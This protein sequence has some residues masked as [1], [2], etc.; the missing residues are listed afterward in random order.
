MCEGEIKARGTGVR[1][2]ERERCATDLVTLKEAERM[3]LLVIYGSASRGRRD[4]EESGCRCRR[5]WTGLD[6]DN[7]TFSSPNLRVPAASVERPRPRPSELRCQAAN[8]RTLPGCNAHHRH[9]ATWL[10][11]RDLIRRLSR[12]RPRPASRAPRSV[13]TTSNFRGRT[14][15]N[16][17]S[18][19]PSSTTLQLPARLHP[20]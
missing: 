3:R 17:T 15:D 11:A 18:R 1:G 8:N 4:D 13:I 10:K 5:R 16:I 6:G 2:I 19:P 9:A 14:R 20:L 7:S 12:D